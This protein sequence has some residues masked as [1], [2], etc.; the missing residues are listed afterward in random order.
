GVE[1]V[2]VQGET[3]RADVPPA[4][5]R[6]VPHAARLA[7]VVRRDVE[8]RGLPLVLVSDG[9]AARRRPRRDGPAARGSVPR[10]VAAVGPRAI[11]SLSLH[12]ARGAPPDRRLVDAHARRAVLSG[13]ATEV[14]NLRQP[15]K[16]LHETRRTG[17]KE[18]MRT[19]SGHVAANH[20]AYLLASWPPGLQ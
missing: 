12:V 14:V 19:T 17:A 15:L 9:E 13:G 8:R 10:S 2:R 5:G 20:P 3:R 4:A 6:A 1:G 18:V 11:G 7:D 16:T